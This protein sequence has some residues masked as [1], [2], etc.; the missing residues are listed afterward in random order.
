MTTEHGPRR[1]RWIALGAALVVVALSVSILSTVLD[2]QRRG[3]HALEQL[4]VN[5]LGQLTRSLDARVTA[6]YAAIGGLARVPYT[7]APRDPGDANRLQQLQALNPDAKTGMMLV[8]TSATITSGTLLQGDVIGSRLR[9]PGLDAALARGRPA[10]LP[11]APGVTTSAP[12]IGY[13]IPLL[14]TGGTVRGAFVFEA[15]IGPDSPFTQEVAELRRGRT[16]QF[17]FVDSQGI[18]VAS[19]DSASIAKPYGN[20]SLLARQLGFHRVGHQ[21]AALATVPSVGWKAI[22]TQDAAE[23][24]GGLGRRIDTA[25]V[26]LIVGGLVAAAAGF[27][28]LLRR[29]RRAR[30]E[31]R[32]LQEINRTTEEFISIV[33]HELRTPVAGVVGFLQ[34]TADHW[35]VM[36]DDARREAVDRALAN[37]RRLY[38]F[39]QEILDTSRLEDGRLVGE[40]DLI[41]LRV[42]LEV[43]VAARRELNPERLIALWVPDE[44]VFVQA[45]DNRIR[46][47]FSN[48][49]DNAVKHSPPSSPVSLRVELED[50]AV[51]VHVSD[52]GPGLPPGELDRIFDRF[53]RGRGTSVQGSGLGLHICR[54]IVEAH[55]GRI[56]AESAEGRGATFTVRLPLRSA[57]NAGAAR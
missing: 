51:V 6:G 14:G 25:I 37:A 32:R 40:F 55:H 52:E 38:L 49:L 23:F 30:L 31:Q 9:R 7:L 12:T 44:P 41:D 28:A 2:A 50:D 3:R 36:S 4:Q 26:L 48:L 16:G 34:T 22:F 56:W 43:A 15:D 20:P 13:L 18:V 54:Q 33:S 17:S 39:S 21:V 1:D 35:A 5:Q 11:V 57:S 8:D 19:S 27:F 53:V 42:E 46:Q 47:V 45:D 29:L 24:D 10:V